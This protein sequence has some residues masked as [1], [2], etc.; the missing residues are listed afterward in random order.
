MF[1]TK[2][3][4]KEPKDLPSPPTYLGW[5][6]PRQRPY[7]LYLPDVAR[8]G[9]RKRFPPKTQTLKPETGSIKEEDVYNSALNHI[10]MTELPLSAY[11]NVD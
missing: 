5:N 4:H 2:L 3:V 6:L 10:N 7:D 1:S 9:Y 11:A 8:D